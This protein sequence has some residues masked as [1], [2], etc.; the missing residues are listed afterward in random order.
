MLHF[1]G[2]YIITQ[3]TMLFSSLASRKRL[4]AGPGGAVLYNQFSQ[5]ID[6]EPFQC[7]Y[8]HS[9]LLLCCSVALLEQRERSDE[10]FERVRVP[11]FIPLEKFERVKCSSTAAGELLPFAALERFVVY[12]L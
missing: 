4:G 8:G 1:R 9:P 5:A 3:P 11:L 7:S 12:R 6:N 2:R 10:I